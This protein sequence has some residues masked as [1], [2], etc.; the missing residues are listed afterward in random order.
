[1]FEEIFSHIKGKVYTP[2]TRVFFAVKN[3]KGGE[4]KSS[5]FQPLQERDF[6]KLNI[7]FVDAG[8]AEL[9]GAPSFSLQIIRV[10]ACSYEDLKVVKQELKEFYVLIH[11]VEKE[12]NLVYHVQTFGTEW[13][14]P[15]IDSFDSSLT[16][17]EHR[18][19]P[20][21]VAD[22][23]RTLSE[24][25]LMQSL[26]DADIIL[27]DGDL[28]LQSED[29]KNMLKKLL[30]RQILIGGLSKTNTL[31]TNTGDSAI[32]ALQRIA[33]Y[34]TWYYPLSMDEISTY[35]VKL[36]AKSEYVFRCD[37]NTNTEKANDLFCQL[38]K[39]A[40]DPVF[41]GYPYGFI[42]VDRIARVSNQEKEMLT[43]T[44]FTLAEKEAEL[45]RP[46]LK[47]QDAHR[48]LDTIG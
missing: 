43:L 35:F 40:R 13:Q 10:A 16:K 6:K 15:E 18:V 45:L 39:H 11:L 17:G 32:A 27:R 42:A 44:F 47:S 8:N 46:Y 31:V 36:H 21:A 5:C 29:E 38:S 12:K 37:V 7:A 33:P 34:P 30:E 3:K 23:V 26:K 41:L 2:S 20:A 14:F 19:I 9:L 22:R 28:E 4:L 24:L 25:Y 1:M 48:V